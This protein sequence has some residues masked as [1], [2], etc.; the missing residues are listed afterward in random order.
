MRF[1][2][3]SN[4][5]R[6]GCYQSLVFPLNIEDPVGAGDAFAAALIYGLLQDQ[7]NRALI[8]F[9]TAACALKHSIKGDFNLASV[10]DIE[11]LATNNAAS[12]VQR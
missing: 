3:K 5:L 1:G 8:N 7:D 11:K 6:E 12:G 4:A 10:E 9:A 2:R